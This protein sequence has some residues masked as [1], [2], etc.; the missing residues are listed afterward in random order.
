MDTYLITYDLN[1]PGQEYN[2]L[3]EKIKDLSS[4]WWHHLDS[5]WLIKH[6]GP[7][8]VIRDGITPKLDS[9][10]SLLVVKLT[11]EGAWRG[12]DSKGSEWLKKNL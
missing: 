4:I 9:N 3:Y 11:G 6:E 2:E 8:T 10:D 12:I 7:S 1:K 5:T